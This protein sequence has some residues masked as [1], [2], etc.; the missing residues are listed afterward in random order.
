MFYSEIFIVVFLVL[1]NGLLAMSELA[2]VSARKSRLEGMARDG[3]KGAATALSLIDDPSRFLSTVQIG[4]TLVGIIAG[5]YSGATLGDRLGN[6]LSDF[7]YMGPYS[8]TAGIAIVVISITY[9]S[10]IVGELVPKRIAL[11]NPERTAALVARP[12]KM[13]SVAGAPAVWLLKLSTDSVLSLL[14][15]DSVRGSQVSE[16]EIKSLIAEGTHAGI[17]VPQEREM[18]EG[19]LRLADRSVG[20]IMTPRVDM[21]WLD[22]NA[23]PDEIA[24]VVGENRF[25]RFPVCDGSVDEI[26]GVVHVKDIVPPALTSGTLSLENCM[27]IAPFVPENKEVLRLLERFKQDKVHVAIVVDEYG[28]T[29]GIVTLTDILEAIAGDLPELGEEDELGMRQRADGSWLVDGWMPID[30]FEAALRIK[31]GARDYN[32]LAGFA[33]SRFGHL[34]V[35]GE[36]FEFGGWRFE[37]ADMDGR[38]IDKLIVALAGG[39]ASGVEGSGHGLA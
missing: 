3:N 17:F 16:E 4:I 15:L 11:A 25:S 20:T 38:R 32:T 22:R 23:S 34:P 28:S 9:L 2:V 8:N 7:D 27:T 37:V 14:G 31:T 21:I 10:L 24:R 1:I 19:V 35:A 30:E 5:A 39:I 26:T 29:L 12:M 6:W 36:S 13:L 33:L 18:I